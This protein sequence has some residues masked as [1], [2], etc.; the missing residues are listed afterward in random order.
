M[1]RLAGLTRQT[2]SLT[3]SLQSS[4]PSLG[5]WKGPDQLSGFGRAMHRLRKFIFWLLLAVLSCVLLELVSL[6]FYTVSKNS[7]FSFQLIN[8][9]REAV[10]RGDFSDVSL[11]HSGPRE[12][13]WISQNDSL[14]LH[15]YLGDVREP[16]KEKWPPETRVAVNEFGF[17]V[18][19]RVPFLDREHGTVVVVVTGG[20]VAE[21]FFYYSTNVLHEELQKIPQFRGR[22]FAFIFLGMRGYK[23]PQQ[24]LAVT[25]YFRKSISS[26]S[27]R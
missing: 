17:M 19:D 16:G 14:V 6:C 4:P 3:L 27:C 23:Q 8:G 7:K 2:K 15:P 10:L 21:H 9:K 25:Y 22:K 1:G 20:S 11:T 12:A 13:G 26:S 5:V 24:L 18:K